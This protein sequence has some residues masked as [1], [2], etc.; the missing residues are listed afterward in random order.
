MKVFAL[1]CLSLLIILPASYAD[2]E[3]KDT[4]TIIGTIHSKALEFHSKKGRVAIVY[5]DNVDGK[6]SPPQEHAVMNQKGKEFVPHVLPILV[7]TTVDFL[8]SDELLHNVFSPDDV[9]DKF[10]LGTWEKGTTKS[11][12]FTKT[13]TAAI[14]CNK[15]PEMEAWI[16]VFQNPYFAITGEDGSYKIENVPEGTYKL[17]IWHEKIKGMPIKEV[18]VEAGREVRVDFEK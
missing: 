9:A 5:I 6:F 13:G 18:T 14:L 16:V 3:N 8:N 2:G 1:I 17:N 10:N 4:G 7:G 12:I 11:H 15:H